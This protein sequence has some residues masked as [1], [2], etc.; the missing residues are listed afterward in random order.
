[1][2][3]QR[4]SFQL[5]HVDAGSCNACEQE[6]T[7]LLSKELDMQRYGI[8]MVASPRHADGLVVTGPVTDTMKTA[9]EKVWESVPRPRKLIA[10]GDC[11]VGCGVFQ[12]AYASHGGVG[13]ALETPDLEIRGCPPDPKKILKKLNP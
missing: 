5:R 6:L 11:A 7:A 9:L 12:A 3:L 2:D 13:A 4:K 8:D 10:L 1:M